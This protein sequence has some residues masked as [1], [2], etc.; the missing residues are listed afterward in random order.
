[1]NK[2]VEINDSNGIV[3]NIQRYSIHDG[4]GIRTT[5]FL[6]GC[7]LKCFW[8]QNPESQSITPVILFNRDTCSLCGYCAN[9]CPNN[10]N[11]LSKKGVIFDRT[12]CVGCGICVDVCPTKSRVL[13]GKTMTMDEV[14]DIVLKDKA[15]FENSNGGI[16]LSGG[17]PIVQKQFALHLLQKSKEVGLNTAIETSGFTPWPAL[18]SIIEYT[19][20][21]YY[22]IKCIN[23]DK[24]LKATGKEN[25]L[26]LENAKKL[27]RE[28][29]ILTKEKVMKIRIPLIPG[30]NDSIEDM[31]A[32]LLFMKE[33]LEMT[34]SDLEILRYNNLGEPKY[35][36]L[37]MERPNLEPQPEEYIEKLKAI[38]NHVFYR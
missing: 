6:K 7:P 1:M 23:S 2:H 3:F 15:F 10:A 19:D 35:V 26:I 22:D 20:F 33:E 17:D 24:H 25:A 29:E 18:K 12:K 4:P 31:Y 16:T 21:I 37:D 5:V 32:V 36:R 38:I 11:S 30:F 34:S 13:S 28:K 27:A 8:C 14:M 9:V